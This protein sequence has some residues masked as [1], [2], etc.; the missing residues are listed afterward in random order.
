MDGWLYDKN[1]QYP[2]AMKN[3]KAIGNPVFTNENNLD[4]IFGF[5]FANVICPSLFPSVKSKSVQGRWAPRLV[6]KNKEWLSYREEMNK[7]LKFHVLEAHLAE[8]GLVKK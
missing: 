4:N 3:P 1:S 7:V 6:N 2:A 5:V 8:S